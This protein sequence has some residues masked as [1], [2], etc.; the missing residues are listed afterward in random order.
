MAAIPGFLST[1]VTWFFDPYNLAKLCFYSLV[2]N[3]EKQRQVAYDHRVLFDQN[4][5]GYV[6]P[7]KLNDLPQPPD[8]I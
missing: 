1:S 8:N 3:V 6:D 4:P 5:D 2:G 7:Q